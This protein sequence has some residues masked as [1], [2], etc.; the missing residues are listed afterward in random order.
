MTRNWNLPILKSR[1]HR[2]IE[3]VDPETVTQSLTQ[4]HVP[5]QINVQ[6]KVSYNQTV[7]YHGNSTACE[8]YSSLWKQL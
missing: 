8:V 3:V 7:L 1:H 6:V 2:R 5:N 4:C